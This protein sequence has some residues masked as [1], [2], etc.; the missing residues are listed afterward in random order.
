MASFGEEQYPPLNGP[1]RMFD[2]REKE[3]ERRFETY[4]ARALI[5]LGDQLSA[6]GLVLTLWDYQQDRVVFHA[7][8]TK[9]GTKWEFRVEDPE[10]THRRT[11]RTSRLRPAFCLH[12]Q[13]CYDLNLP[14][15][16]SG[17]L[18]VQFPGIKFISSEQDV[19]IRHAL[20]DVS[21]DVTAMLLSGE[22][23]RLERC[24]TDERKQADETRAFVAYLSK[25][26][27]CVSSISTALVQS[28]N[29][30]KVLA[31]VLEHML[32][33]LG[34]RLGVIY[35]LET[36]QCVSFHC[37]R[38][39]TDHKEDPWFRHYFQ[40]SMRLGSTAADRSSFQVRSVADN[41]RFPVGLKAYL[42]SQKI[43][44]VLE[45][46]VHCRDEFLGLGML[47][48]QK[49][50]H[51]PSS[52]R[53]L[54]IALNMIGLFLE[55]IALM[56]DLDRQVKV[57]S[58]ENLEMEKKNRFLL[59]YMG[60]QVPPNRPGSRRI[61]PTD[62]LL[63]EIERSRNTA[64]LAELASGVA[65]QIRNPLSNL[66]YALH[67]LK[68]ES[69]AESEKKDLIDSATERVEI[70][71]RTITQFIQYTRI[72][73]LKL[74]P[75]S[76]NQV[77]KNALRSFEAWIGFRKIELETFFDSHLPVTKIDVFLVSQVFNNIIKNAVEAMPDSG[78]LRV[79][80]RKLKI[81]HGPEPR[82]EFAEIIFEDDGPGIAPKDLDKVL[83]PFYSRKEDG[84][85]LGLALVDHIVRAHGGAV[86]LENRHSGGTRVKL[87]L[88][89][90]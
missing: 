89:I 81:R 61:S 16:W 1:V 4:A 20:R 60:T 34:A 63:D 66:L 22:V 65:H 36:G 41:P 70:I 40:G 6:K 52:T 90:R 79:A 46:A 67:L 38:S 31:R 75:E 83:K 77:L 49:N 11:G 17:M 45:F 29:V 88:P 23:A 43:D 87:Y 58:Q 30:E 76:I 3:A 59:E 78:S 84:L 54:M 68:Q 50:Q 19:R 8:V 13:F 73:D 55:H 10:V 35:F 72:P 74:S 47:G 32:P 28:F 26:L 53:L 69:V 7:Q 18:T 33:F 5:W 64:L 24:L 80:T 71:N 2:D 9:N 62:R 82:L 25:E 44:S 57:M 51:H 85:G 56:G 14:H 37:P 48:L 21:R 39:K 42:A 86:S 15:R 12:S 27:Y